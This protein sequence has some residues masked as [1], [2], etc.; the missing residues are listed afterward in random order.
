MYKL[1][2]LL[3]ALVLV[4]TQMFAQENSPYSRYG[5]GLLQAQQ[6]ISNR[7]MGGASIADRSKVLINPENPSSYSALKLTS[8]QLGLSGSLFNIKSATQASRTGGFGLSYVNL[9]FPVGKRTGISFG[10]L[11]YSRVKY[12]M[13]LET[14]IP[15][16]SDVIYDYFG[17][18]SIQRVYLGAAH[19]YKGFSLGFNA[20]YL[21]GNYQN[22]VSETFTDTLNILNTDILR[23]TILSGL[24]WDFGASYHYKIKEERYLN[25][26]ATFSNKSNVN[27]KADRYW[28]S[29]IGDVSSGIYSY[30]VDSVVEKKGKVVLPSKI[31]FGLQYGNGDFWKIGVDFSTSDWSQ[32]RSYDVA[33]SFVSSTAIRVG[34]EFTPD[35][36]DKFNAWKRVSYRIGG[37]YVNEPIKLKNIQ[38]KST[39]LTVGL[40]YPIK[41]TLRSIGQFNAAF[42]VGKRGTLDNDLLQENF[43]RFSIGVTLNDRWFLKRRY[44]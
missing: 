20:G 36:N 33:D 14:T 12:N 42:E 19:E 41:R 44:D 16:I 1:R 18:G 21:F 27:A 17:G 39:A 15:N 4:S 28:Y 29:A 30:Q 43:T 31:G 37:Y 35:V 40:G 24:V 7:G 10:L 6:N 38:L 13:R 22:N 8:Y 2:L 25:I 5:I 26:G 23:R 34:G 32:Y 9:A 11:P 3:T